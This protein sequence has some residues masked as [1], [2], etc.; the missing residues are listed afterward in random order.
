MLT[1]DAHIRLLISTKGLCHG[2]AFFNQLGSVLL[3]APY[4]W[5]FAML[6]FAEPVRVY[7]AYIGR[8]SEGNISKSYTARIFVMY[9]AAFLLSG[10]VGYLLERVRTHGTVSVWAFLALVLA[11]TYLSRRWSRRKIDQIKSNQKDVADE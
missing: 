1:Y 10:V 8:K 3:N 9:V 5:A 7:E 6:L 11:L 4:S 2:H